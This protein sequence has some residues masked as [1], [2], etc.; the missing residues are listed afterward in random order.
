MVQ[1][2]VLER[3]SGFFFRSGYMVGAGIGL[4][5]RGVFVAGEWLTG[6]KRSE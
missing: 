1:V 5:I 2:K 6:A 3:S 4:M